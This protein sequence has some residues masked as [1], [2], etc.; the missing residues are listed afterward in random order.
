ME[1]V[2]DCYRL[3]DQADEDSV[4][5][6]AITAAS[7]VFPFAPHLGSEVVDRLAGVRIWEEPWP[8]ADQAMLERD[9]FEL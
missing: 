9:T 8:V 6:A 7:L 2:N 5:F 1:V 4:R 3:K